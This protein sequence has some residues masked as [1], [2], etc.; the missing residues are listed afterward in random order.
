[1]K[2]IS[3]SQ[4]GSA[5]VL[6]LTN[7]PQ[8]ILKPHMVRIRNHASSINPIDWKIRSGQ[9]KLLSGMR[10]PAFCGS[11][12]AGEV[13][14]VGSKV[15]NYT[16]GD[17]VY[18]FVN[19]LKGGGFAEEL[20]VAADLIAPI[21]D[22]INMA[23]AGVIPLTGLTAYTA[24]TQLANVKKNDR[25]V[26][27]GCSG[28]VGVMAIQI[29]KALGAY[30]IGVCSSSNKQLAFSLGADEVIDYNAN[31]SLSGIAPI[32]VFFDVVS[33]FSA[34]GVQHMLDQGGIYINTLPKPATL[35][36]Q[37]LCNRMKKQ[38]QYTVLVKPHGAHLEKFNQWLATGKIHPVIEKSYPLQEIAFAHEHSEAG[39]VKGKL[40]IVIIN[41]NQS[42]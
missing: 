30:V 35:L 24:L 18:G 33:S 22:N 28:G 39:H 19:P 21:P 3:Y 4:Y 40:S 41:D 38:K 8:P 26:I 10:P 1:M 36:G 31:P 15:Q 12:F 11:D 25:V 9:L 32:H 23:E 29:A 20:C 34:K 42:S 13:I 37:A 17:R 7:A 2:A 16:I 6:K 27:H 14:E 5:E